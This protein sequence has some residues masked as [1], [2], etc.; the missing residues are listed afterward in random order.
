[1]AFNFGT[2]NQVSGIKKELI[3]SYLDTCVLILNHSELIF[4]HMKSIHFIIA[5]LLMVAGLAQAQKLLTVE[6]ATT[7]G[8]N[9]RL[10]PMRTM[11][12]FDTNGKGLLVAQ[13]NQLVRQDISNST[14]TE[15]LNLDNINLQLSKMGLNP[16]PS[17]RGYTQADDCFWFNSGNVFVKIKGET[18]AVTDTICLPQTATNIDFLPQQTIFAYTVGNSLWVRNGKAQAQC[19]G[20]AASADVVY[21]QSVHR[22][23]FGITKGTFWNSNCTKLAFYKMDQSMVTSYPIVDYLPRVAELAATQYPMAGM[24]SHKVEIGIYDVATSAVT[25]LQMG[26]VTDRYF[27]NLSWTP[28]NKTLLVAELN[29]GQNHMQMKR[30]DAVSGALMAQL[31]EEKSDK[32]VEPEHPA[33]FVPFMVNTFIWQ[34]CRD[35]FNHLY[36]YNIDGQMLKQITSGPWEVT[37][38]LGFNTT[39]KSVIIETTQPSP[40]ERHIYKVSLA[41]G[42]STRLTS[43]EGFHQAITDA[44]GKY[45][46]DSYSSLNNPGVAQI[47]DTKGKKIR[48]LAKSDNPLSNY[49]MPKIKML[50]LKSDDGST[51]HGRMILPHNFDASKKY[52]V[53]VYVYGGPHS[54]LVNN[55]WLGNAPL[56]QV[57]MAQKGYVIFTIDN[58]GTSYRGRDFEQ[59]IY[60]QLGKC[61]MTDQMQGISYLK[62]LP[63]V[64]VA[65][66]GIYGW[67]FGGFMTTNMML[68]HSDVFKVGVAGGPV[69]DWKYYEIM[70]GERYM[71][72]PNE[73]PDGY[74]ASNLIDQAGNLKGKLLIIHGGIDATVVPQHSMLFIESCIKKGKQVDFFMYPTHEHNVSG[75]DRIHLNQKIFNYFDENL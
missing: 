54:Q 27:T 16:L 28:D 29:R 70:Y 7:G 64:D 42:K 38:V 10:L 25:Y 2:K 23:E 66:I 58:R 59:A 13:A 61:E 37:N 48:V 62:S 34:S 24:T 11:A 40:T 68:N 41:N 72:T 46:F 19:V 47:I 26:D 8:A 12:T 5:G 1:V 6:E 39:E 17:L 30:Y 44:N 49:S 56:W 65:R 21:G 43:D 14:S 71:D 32:W 35:G 4:K 63:F 60:R 18:N 55:S 52:P 3:S 22:N 53:V 33:M 50:Q 15:V 36:L 73:N 9:R 20:T 57:A 75:R 31:F 67:S 69:M 74:K 51:L 45:L